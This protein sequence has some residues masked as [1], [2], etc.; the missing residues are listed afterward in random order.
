MDVEYRK[1]IPDLES[2]HKV[3]SEPLEDGQASI[4]ESIKLVVLP[5][6]N[7]LAAL[8]LTVLAGFEKGILFVAKQIKPDI[9]QKTFFIK[10]AFKQWDRVKVGLIA[11]TL[12]EKSIRPFN[13][14]QKTFRSFVIDRRL[15]ALENPQDPDDYLDLDLTPPTQE[16]RLAYYHE[17]QRDV[18]FVRENQRNRNQ[19]SMWTFSRKFYREYSPEELQ[20]NPGLKRVL[21][22]P[23]ELLEEFVGFSNIEEKGDEGRGEYLKIPCPQLRG[24]CV[25]LRDQ[26]IK[27][28]FGESVEVYPDPE[29]PYVRFQG[30]SFKALGEK[31]ELEE[32]RLRNGSIFLRMKKPDL[33][34]MNFLKRAAIKT[35]F[36]FAMPLVKEFFRQA[37]GVNLTI[38]DLGDHFE[39]SVPFT[40]VDDQIAEKISEESLMPV[41]KRHVTRLFHYL[42]P[43]FKRLAPDPDPL[44]QRSWEDLIDGFQKDLVDQAPEAFYRLPKEKQVY[45]D[46]EEYMREDPSRFL[47]RDKGFTDYLNLKAIAIPEG[48]QEHELRIPFQMDPDYM[49]A[50]QKRIGDFLT[51]LSG[52]FK[53][54]VELGQDAI[55]NLEER[56]LR[57]NEGCRITV[58]NGQLALEPESVKIDGDNVT[59]T[60]KSPSKN[61]GPVGRRLFD[62]FFLVAVPMIKTAVFRVCGLKLDVSRDQDGKII[63]SLPLGAFA[64]RA[65]EEV[66][67]NKK[68]QFL[69]NFHDE[70]EEVPQEEK[71]PKLFK[72]QD[73][74]LKLPENEEL[75]QY[76]QAGQVDLGDQ[77]PQEA[78]EDALI[79]LFLQEEFIEGIN[80]EEQE[81][82][83]DG[84]QEKFRV[85]FKMPAML[86]I[87]DEIGKLLPFGTQVEFGDHMKVDFQKSTF[88][89][90]ENCRVSALGGQVS[91]RPKSL[92]I[93]KNRAVLTL[94]SPFNPDDSLQERLKDKLFKLSLSVIRPIMQSLI[95]RML[96]VELII[97]K[98]EETGEFKFS[99]SLQD[100][101]NKAAQT[102]AEKNVPAIIQRRL[103]ELT[104]KLI[105]LIQRQEQVE[106]VPEI[107]KVARKAEAKEKQTFVREHFEP[108]EYVPE[109]GVKVSTRPDKIGE[110][111]NVGEFKLRLGADFQVDP[112]AL[113]VKFSEGFFFSLTESMPEFLSSIPGLLGLYN[114]LRPYFGVMGLG[115]LEDLRLEIRQAQIDE[116]GQ[117][118]VN[119]KRPAMQFATPGKPTFFEDMAQKFLN[120]IFDQ[121]K[122][123]VQQILAD[124]LQLPGLTFESEG[125]NI[126]LKVPLKQVLAIP[127]L[128]P[129]A[130]MISI[131]DVVGQPQ[132]EE[133]RSEKQ[134]RFNLG[135]KGNHHLVAFAEIPSDWK[136]KLAGLSEQYGPAM[137]VRL[138][139]GFVLRLGDKTLDFSE[140][141]FAFKM[142]PLLHPSEEEA[143]LQEENFLQDRNRLLK[144]ECLQEAAR[145]R[146]EAYLKEQVVNRREE[147]RLQEEEVIRL[148]GEVIRLQEESI[149]LQ[150]RAAYL[151]DEEDTRLQQEEVFNPV[152]KGKKQRAALNFKFEDYYLKLNEVALTRKGFAFRGPHGK[153]IAKQVN[154]DVFKEY[155]FQ[156]KDKKIKKEESSV[157][158]VPFVSKLNEELGLIAKPKEKRPPKTRFLPQQVEIV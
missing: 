31:V 40:D 18:K 20:L 69:P 60:I 101:L 111:C 19:R 130:Q 100:L 65:F 78:Q 140:D 156:F 67:V 1:V 151:Q 70:G 57:F 12:S 89:F 146:Q 138:G 105:S 97:E 47:L 132:V 27:M 54:Q 90:A 135:E 79:D 102:M 141:S 115:F 153:K 16:E 74:S 64:N 71:P 46:D 152:M 84:G 34:R 91:V 6:I 122:D 3:K 109:Q 123:K 58:L 121:G 124:G 144:E 134:I 104:S 119:L 76:F 21:K 61:W 55:I 142:T 127:K 62:F 26:D 116:Y 139:R 131:E 106:E 48:A 155:N 39:C 25:A 137:D 117:V 86:K 2:P 158:M 93:V 37:Y 147:A 29:S 42:R 72:V 154:N 63:F 9:G 129:I 10:Y 33:S 30:F 95:S 145:L 77:N 96:G 133:E 98:D 32:V 68:Y 50:L 148:Q 82:Y 149:R 51:T 52:G 28:S 88:E 150:K 81:E 94:G 17:C 5:L 107:E 43:E 92:E 22:K 143:L 114:M 87:Q 11:L 7:I 66:V 49:P 53:T 15:R 157:S 118:T 24:Q 45:R 80:L 41:E 36:Y 4:Q 8:P 85:N 13:H 14:N 56:A 83:L 59:L 23:S 44:V 126:Q 103:G 112:E 120:L 125:E 99:F 108:F 73:D 136:T 75:V 35:A 113:S 38:R 128:A 110:S